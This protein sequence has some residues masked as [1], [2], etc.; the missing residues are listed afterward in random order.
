MKPGRAGLIGVA[1]AAAFVVAVSL[2]ISHRMEQQDV[3]SAPTA[4]PPS[5][6]QPQKP[7]NPDLSWFGIGTAGQRPA[8][9]PAVGTW[10]AKPPA[11][12]PGRP[13]APAPRPAAPGTVPRT[14]P[15]TVPAPVPG[16][17]P[18]PPPPPPPLIGA[19]VDLGGLGVG[20][21]VG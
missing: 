18:A 1:G 13:A 16:P 11:A 12:A 7:F 15:G 9:P 3:S 10:P 8:P 2:A 20:L 21:G 4:T 17:V 14:A 6:V 19:G 5:A